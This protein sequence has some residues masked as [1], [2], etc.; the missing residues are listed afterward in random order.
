MMRLASGAAMAATALSAT[1]PIEAVT[2]TETTIDNI[3][4]PVA[5]AEHHHPTVEA[6]FPIVFFGKL[7][8][9]MGMLIGLYAPIQMRWRN[10]DC[11]GRAFS[12]GV[13]LLQYSKDFD[14]PF[15]GGFGGIFN[16]LFRASFSFFTIFKTVKTCSDQYTTYIKNDSTPWT[17]DYNLMAELDE[18]QIRQQQLDGYWTHP[19]VEATE[20][21]VADVLTVG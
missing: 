10:Y 6:K 2:G 8:L 14:K 15:K 4:E 19:V 16:V 21:G 7:D 9:F 5:V 20:F 3:L 1:T 13:S 11:R 18:D 12:M 17:N